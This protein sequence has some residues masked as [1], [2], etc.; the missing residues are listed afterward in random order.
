MIYIWYYNRTLFVLAFND[1]ITQ[2]VLRLWLDGISRNAIAKKLGVSNGTTS[3]IIKSLEEKD[4]AI[5]LM[6]ELALFCRRNNIDLSDLLFKIPF[7]QWSRRSA[8]DPVKIASLLADLYKELELKGL[9]HEQAY[10]TIHGLSKL[11]YG[12]NVSLRELNR[13]IRDKYAKLEQ[14]NSDIEYREQVRLRSTA[15]TNLALER[16]DVTMEDLYQFEGLRKIF[17][18]RYGGQKNYLKTG[19]EEPQYLYGER[20]N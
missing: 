14:I 12:K 8:V 20:I 2:K 16:N 6:R 9:T 1:A 4:F 17:L 11:A 18:Q 3:A 10:D 13:E 7:I 19:E 5:P 15:E